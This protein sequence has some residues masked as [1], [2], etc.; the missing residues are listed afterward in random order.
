[1]DSRSIV[2]SFFSCW[3]V[4]DLEMALAHL[5]P[6]AVYELHNGPD[7]RPLA[8]AYK[9]IQAI[10]ELGYG[11]LADFDYLAYEPTIVSVDG[12]VVRAQVRAKLRHRATRHIIEGSQRSVF[13]L[14]D[15]LIARI[16]LY[17]DAAR[18]QAFMRM[19]REAPADGNWLAQF[20]L[21]IARQ[22]SGAG[23]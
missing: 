9:G 18:L 7:A 19:V 3:R 16:D 12:H 13:E 23:A 6:D 2:A 20:D 22:K 17:E 10:R 5:H 21:A 15:G 8:G 14:K 11:V 4:Q 1:M